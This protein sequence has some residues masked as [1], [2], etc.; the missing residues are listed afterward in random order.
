MEQK[1][2]LTLSRV[3]ADALVKCLQRRH[4]RLCDIKREICPPENAGPYE[5]EECVYFE[6]E[7]EVVGRVLDA[8]RV[9]LDTNQ[10]G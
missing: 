3:D 6:Q 4:E 1:I 2:T 9:G 7:D 5:Q 8:L 10:A